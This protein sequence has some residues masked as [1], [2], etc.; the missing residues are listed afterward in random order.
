MYVSLKSE[1]I[2]LLTL[3]NTKGSTTSNDSVM[4]PSARS[5]SFV[6][7]CPLRNNRQ[8]V[9]HRLET[10][11]LPR[12]WAMSSS[13]QLP[14]P[15]VTR[16]ASLNQA[17]ATLQHCWAKLATFVQDHPSST[18]TSPSS[19]GSS[20]ILEERQR[21]KDWLEQWE[22]AFTDFLTNAMATMHTEDI[23]QSRVLKTNHLACTILAADVDTTEPAFESEYNAIVELSGAVLKSRYQARSAQGAESKTT[24]ST[25][26]TAPGLDVFDPLMVVVAQCN[27]DS[28]RT[29]AAELLRLRQ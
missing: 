4:V 14:M 12:P 28:V 5:A 19:A 9:L 16:V 26:F 13:R 2:L 22:L 3:H 25:S 24:S 8:M 7:P 18:S 21:F 17:H 29:R 27:I 10:G 11:S 23:T 15:T 6:A 20:P 1:P